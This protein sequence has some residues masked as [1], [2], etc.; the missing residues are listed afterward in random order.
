MALKQLG[1]DNAS[2]YFHQFVVRGKEESESI[3]ADILTEVGDGQRRLPRTWG[4]KRAAKMIGRSEGWLRDNDPDVPRNEA[5]HGRWTLARINEL[6]KK[7]GTLY[8]RPAGS[9]PI[10]MAA[11]KLKGGVGNTT[12]VCH[13]AHYFAM[14]GLKVLVWDLDPQSSATSILAAL[15]P[16]AHLEDEDLPNS[17]LLEDMS[18]FPGCIRKT[19][20]HNVHLVPSNSALQDLDLKLASQQQSDSE[21]QIAPHERVR[22]ALDLVK[23]N[24]D[25]ILI[26]CA[27]ALGMLTL[28]ALMAGNALINPMRPSL[29]DLASYVMFTGSLQLFYQELAELPLKYHRIV[30]TAHKNTTGNERMENRTRAMYGDAVLT[31]RIMDSEEI[32]NAATKLSTVYCLEKPIG[33][34]ETYNRA[35]DTLDQCYG[36]IFEDLKRVWE[37]EGEDV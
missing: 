32:S 16:D 10:I 30:L 5:G 36:E 11:S 17:A 21:F 3:R 20:F 29:L 6:R 37:M 33:A 28:N 35:I 13:A 34:R 9:E 26:D 1:P 24:Y 27:P 8:Q 12:F 14:Q 18:L 7:A 19:Y 4:A 22:A 25:I 31:R 23:D 2:A 15:V